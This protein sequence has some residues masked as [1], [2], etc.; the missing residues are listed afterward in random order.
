MFP[1]G[2][3]DSPS[4]EDV[5]ED[6]A[7]PVSSAGS[8]GKEHVNPV[9][10]AGG[11]SEKVEHGNPREDDQGKIKEG[12][13]EDEVEGVPCHHLMTHLPKSRSCDTCKRA[14]L[15]EQPHRRAENQSKNMK[16]A[17]MVEAPTFFLEKLSVDHIIV[18]DEI[19]HKGETCT[20][21]M[22][23][24]FSGFTSMVPC[25]HKTAEEV[26]MAF[27]R[28]CGKK[29]PGIVQVVSDR[30]PEIKSA[31]RNLGFASEPAA[32]YQKIKNAL[33]ESTIRTI[34]GMTSSIL[35]HSGIELQYWPLAQK[36]LEWA[37]NITAPAR[38]IE[39][40]SEEN[41]SRYEK[42]MGYSIDC[43]MV[44]FGALVWYKDPDPYS[45]GPKGEPALFLG[46]EL[47]DGMLFK[48]CY[49]VWPLEQFQ[50]GVFKEHVLRTIAIPNGQWKFAALTPQSVPALDPIAD[51][52]LDVL[53]GGNSEGYSP[54]IASH[55]LNDK[56]C[57]EFWDSVGR[58]DPAPGAGGPTAEKPKPRRNRPI[59]PLRIAIYGKTPGCDGCKE[60]TY[61]H[62]GECRSRFNKLLDEVEPPRARGKDAEEEVPKAVETTAAEEDFFGLSTPV[63]GKE[64]SAMELEVGPEVVA[65][66][67]LKELDEG[68]GTEEELSAKLANVLHSCTQ[69]PKKKKKGSKKWFVEFCC[70]VNSA[71]CRVSEACS[72]PYLG[73][74][75]EFGDLK[76]PMVIDQVMFWFQETAAKGETIDLYGSI[77]CAPY[78]PLQNLNLAVQGVEYE[79]ALAGKRAE[80]EILVDHF[81]QLSEVALESRGSSSFEWP[82]RNGGWK[83]E[84]ITEMIIHFNMYSCYP[85]GCGMGLEIDGKYPLKEWRI[86]TT[87][88]R[89]AAHLNR[90]R[91]P[92]PHSFKHDP[93][94]GGTMARKSG[95]YNTKMAVAILSALNPEMAFTAVPAM[96]VTHGSVAHQ[97]RGLLMAQTV[98]GMVHTPLSRQE[99]F[100]HPQGKDKIKEE[101]DEMRLLQVWDD[102]DVHEV[103]ELR[104]Q[105]RK[106]GWKVHIAEAMPIGSIKNSESKDKAK[107]KVRLVFR[108]DDTRDENNQLALFRE[109]KSIPAT[110]ATIN[111]VLWYGLR[112]NNIV[113]IADARKAYLQAPIRSETPTYVILP[114]EAWQPSWHRKY[115][116]AAARLLKAMY[117]HP[118]S[119]DDWTQYLDEIVVI[120]LQGDQVEGWPS[121]WHIKSLNVLVAAYVDDLVVA[122]P[123]ESVPMFWQMLSQYI[124]VDTIEE[125]GRYLGRDHLIFEFG[126][127]V[128]FTCPC[129]ITPCHHINCM[130][131]NL[132]KSTIFSTKADFKDCNSSSWDLIL[133]SCP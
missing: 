37:Y 30:A 88:K 13:E 95:V 103:E 29:R 116:R 42:A 54:S 79:Q 120:R 38:G 129:V 89:F 107:L 33:A 101:A 19:G 18:R 51:Q 11:M 69:P 46:A 70:S 77:P 40:D 59:T 1:L 22:V 66:I 23:D 74:S 97:E 132:V 64:L 82:L 108:G 68:R 50:S 52:E 58:D 80:T 65:S 109:L 114:R 104:S 63:T 41:L 72:I 16:E 6:A 100:S 10:G 35:I 56:D 47:T 20:F 96:P 85:S 73:L 21:V 113:Q 125:P 87:S 71:C 123:Q 92:H 81:C 3:G 4:L 31:L 86:V 121:L 43:F 98:L 130:K 115:R 39:T 53:D 8:R 93:I 9:P 122:G 15:Y 62:S 7:D 61:S 28:F 118:T 49:R 5:F 67:Y 32:P 117:G 128:K 34:T 12:E 45:Y 106:E 102:D 91:C 55:D 131:T 105:A 84:Q 75:E 126:G 25:E 119:G 133:V 76:D 111:L 83:Q 2:G 127:G 27:R 94:E 44:P 124:T 60:G 36:Y 48:G 24:V 90:F 99:L 110:I 17:R 78:S 57:K 14:K 26:E 112:V